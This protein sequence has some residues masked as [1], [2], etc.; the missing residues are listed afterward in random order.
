MYDDDDDDDDNNDDDD[1]DDMI[2]AMIRKII[3]ENDLNRCP[4]VETPLQVLS[5]KTCRASMS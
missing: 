4:L 1:D 3:L 2:I 5:E